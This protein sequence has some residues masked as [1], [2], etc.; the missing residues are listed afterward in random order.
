MWNSTVNEW[1]SVRTGPKLD[2]L[3]LHA[4]AIRGKGLKLVAALHH[5][6]HYNGYYQYVPDQSTE[7]LRRLFGQNGATAENQLWYNK[8]QEVI[9]GYQ[10]DLVYQDFDLGLV[11]ESKRLDFLAHYYNQAV[12][13]NKDVV[14]TYKD[15]LD[16][17][18]EVYD[19]ERGGPGSLVSSRTGRPTTASPSTS[20]CYTVGISYYSTQVAAALP[21]RPGQQERQPAAEHRP[22]GRRHH[23]DQQ[24]TILLGIGDCLGASASRSTPPAPGPSTARARPRWAAARPEG[25]HQPRTSA[26]PAARTTP[27]CTP[28]SWAG[29]AARHHHHPG[30]QPVNLGSL[31]SV[32]LLGTPPGPTST[33]RPAPR[34][35]A[36]CT[37][38]CP[39]PTRRSTRWPTWSS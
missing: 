39:R 9:D 37:S 12:A 22:D 26:S 15:G 34:T 5:A 4:N 18:G 6:Y 38:P 32:Q 35:A 7:S 16:N 20:W 33:C 14:A 19:F 29:R 24:R 36:A 2:L 13:W 10:P 8:L 28:R 31:K 23:P 30:L 11:D 27:S 17:K 25:R 21:G 3:Q 1:N